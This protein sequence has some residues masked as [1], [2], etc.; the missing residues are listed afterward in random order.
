MVSEFS[1][2]TYY[3]GFDCNYSS[4]EQFGLNYKINRQDGGMQLYP[5]GQLNTNTELVS[6]YKYQN[7]APWVGAKLH[8][9]LNDKLSFSPFLKAYLFVYKAEADWKLRNDFKH[10]PSFIQTATGTGLSLDAELLYKAANYLDIHANIGV[11][12]LTML[13]GTD[14]TYLSNGRVASGSLKDL[15]MLTSTLNIGARYKF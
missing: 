3:L 9:K 6:T 15:T 14:T 8:Y 5:L 7:Y 11:K 13:K 10:D 1:F 4:F 12:K 2:A